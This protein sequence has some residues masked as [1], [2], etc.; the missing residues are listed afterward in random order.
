MYLINF[1]GNFIEV[2][3]I[4]LKR[5]QLKMYLNNII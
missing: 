5:S 1:D 4:Q 3:K 2:N